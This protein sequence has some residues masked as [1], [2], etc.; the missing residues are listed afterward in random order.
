MVK[1]QNKIFII[2]HLEPKLWNWCIWEYENI[3]RIVGKNKLWITNIK[4]NSDKNRL[5]RIAKIFKESIRDMNLH[6]V[7]I[8]DPE[9]RK[10]LSYKDRKNF[11]FFIFGGI[12][13]DYPPKKRTKKEITRFIKKA[14]ARN[15]GKEQMS[16]DNAVYSVSKIL[17]GENIKRMKFISK[18]NI[19]INEFESVELPYRYN[20]VGKN[21]LIS[22]KVVDYL[23]KKKSF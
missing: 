7:C 23:R 5:A 12:L 2:E 8:L 13:G 19:K 17:N 4:S 1:M 15:I 9:A 3:S 14:G 18:I 16:T 22:R 11:D 20:L 6:R 10:T 21:P